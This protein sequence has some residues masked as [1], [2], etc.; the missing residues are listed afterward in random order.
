M[1]LRSS[2]TGEGNEYGFLIGFGPGLTLE[3]LVMRSVPTG[4]EP[5]PVNVQFNTESESVPM[6]AESKNA[7][8][9]A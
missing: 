3:V 1:K 4:V 9:E 7:P 5:E 8:I 6:E 2:T